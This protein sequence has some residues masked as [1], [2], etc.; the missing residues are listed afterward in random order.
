MTLLVA[1]N[2]ALFD[3]ILA[4]RGRP[5]MSEVGVLGGSPSAL[6]D[7]LPGGTAPTIAL[8]LALSARYGRQGGVRLWHPYPCDE[9]ADAALSIIARAGVDVS[10]L[11]RCDG[12]PARCVLIYDDAGRMAWSGSGPRT[13]MVDPSVLDGVT[14]LVLAPVW[15]EWSDSLVTMA[16]RRGI[17]MTLIGHVPPEARA[18]RWFSVVVDEQQWAGNPDLDVTAA[19]VTDGGKGVRIRQADT[20]RAIPAAPARIVDTTGAGDSFGASFL[21]ALLDGHDAVEAARRAVHR[22]AR[23]CEK[24]G[25]WAAATRP[26]AVAREAD[27]MRRA[28]GA[29]AGLACGDAFGMPNSFLRS[30]AWREVMEPGPADSPYHAGYAAGRITDDTEQALALTCALE[31]GLTEE[32]AARHLLT[33]FEAVGASASLAV[34]PSTMRAMIAYADGASPMETGHAGIT[35]GAAM[36]IAPVGVYGGL[37]GLG[38]VALLDAVVRACW[39]THATS[40]AISGAAAIAAAVAAGIAGR[41]WADGLASALAAAKAGAM[42]GRWVYAPCVA[43]RTRQACAAL[44]AADTM[45]EVAMI[46]SDIVGAGEP[47]TESVPAALAIADWAGG[48]PAVAIEIA[49]NLRGDTDTVAAMAGAVCGAYAGDGL[50]PSSWMEN[51]SAE[52]GLDFDDWVCR[53]SAVAD[54]DRAIRSPARS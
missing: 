44:G 15:G 20:W 28:C 18:H 54:R 13:I 34:G 2:A 41:T 6:R 39:P 3:L 37:A 21:A 11:P 14:H 22:A 4:V 52:N 16:Q 40:P 32:T 51:V 19:A 1:G 45:S 26:V 53:L 12:S 27:P 50:L 31:D 29:L 9:E 43:E 7:W 8:T 35:N 46:V 24:R 5:G 48:N 38:E 23:C 17:P 49:G 36:R 10:H 30:P 47:T 25:A 42:R 33:W